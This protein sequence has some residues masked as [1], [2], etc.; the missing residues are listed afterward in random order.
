[1]QRSF[2]SDCELEVDLAAL[3]ADSLRAPTAGNSRGIGWL[4]LE[5]ATEVD[6]YFDA[7]TDASWRQRSARAEGLGR[8][9]AAA[10]CLSSPAAYLERYAAADKSSSGL[11]ESVEAWPVPYWIG[12]AG[13]TVMAAL[14]LAEEH[15]LATAFLG[16]FRHDAELREAF[17][18]PEEQLI[19]GT[20][21]LGLGDGQ[22]HRSDS[23]LRPGPNR[24]SRV[25]RARWS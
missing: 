4:L 11:G 13:A 24:A 15:G 25:R 16:A 12:D 10:I 19:Y 18:I 9:S 14:L 3:L 5:G 1:M 8:A 23:L 17:S 21:L 20:V 22:D 2:R 7:A 6:R